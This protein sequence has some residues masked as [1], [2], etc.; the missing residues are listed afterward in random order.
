MC[1]ILIKKAGKFVDFET[2]TSEEKDTVRCNV[3]GKLADT[4]FMLQLG[5]KRVAKQRKE[6]AG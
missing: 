4:H 3:T 1:R 6:K 5:Y 2:L